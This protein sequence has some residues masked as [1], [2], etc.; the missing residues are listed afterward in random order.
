MRSNA[1]AVVNMATF[2]SLYRVPVVDAQLKAV[3][4]NIP[5]AGGS[6]G[7][8][9]HDALVLL[10][11]LMDDA[12]EKLNM[13]PIELRLKNVK[14]MGE[15][16]IMFPMETD[17]LESVI[18]LGAEKFHWAEKRSREKG[19]GTTRMGVGMSAYFDT[20][21]GQPI[22]IMDRHITMSLDEDGTV[23]VTTNH[24]DGG[25]NL[26]G[27]CSQIAAE[28]SGL[29]PEDFRYLHGETKGA[30]FDWGM[31]ANS[32]MYT[33]GNLAIKAATELKRQILD[34]ASAR[35]G[36]PV[37]DLDISDGVI[38]VLSDNTKSL[39]IRQFA[40]TAMYSHTGPSLNIFVK[41]SFSPTENPNSTGVVFAEVAVDVETGEVKPT[42]LL[43]VHDC[44]RAINPMTVE[45]QLEGGMIQGLGYALCEELQVN[46]RTGVLE[47][48]NLNTY[49][50]PSTLDVPELEVYIYEEPT[51]SGP[52]GAKSV[53]MSGILGVPAAIGNAIYDAVGVRVKEMPWTAERVRRAIKEKSA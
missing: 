32:G 51:P 49:K 19:T 18:R 40:D 48:D 15:M 21:G 35:L 28:V 22:E 1:T 27:T 50:I 4:S 9:E 24:P 6:R 11:G 39:T 14:H 25:M 10:E 5:E 23:T 44:G 26:L 16:G 42:K 20:S 43:I 2:G 41:E 7:Y 31:G 17:T 3:Y 37:D 13:D 52:F 36:V 53:G 47:T 30:L 38:H 33:A 12:A 29:R 8:G 34:A 45:G 46:P